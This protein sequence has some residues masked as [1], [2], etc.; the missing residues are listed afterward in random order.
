MA[1]TKRVKIHYRKLR[2]D[3][4]QF[5]ASTFRDAV[6]AAMDKILSD[7]SKVK[8]RVRNRL[9][10]V[11][12]QEGAQRLLNHFQAGDHY[13]F[14]T[15]CLFSPGELQALLKPQDAE[16]S[17][18]PEDVLDAWEIEETAAPRGNEY[19]HAISYWYVVGDHFYQIQHASL[20]SKSMEEYFTWL[21]RDQSK[22][23]GAANYVELKTVF[24]RTQVGDLD[25]IKAIEI[26]G[27]VPETV[28]AADLD[29]G[30]PRVVEYDAR[31]TV[32]DKLRAGFAKGRKIL[33][34]LLGEVEAQKI[35]DDMPDEASLEVIV[36]IGYRAKKRKIEKQFMRNLESGLRNIPD[37]EIKVRGRDGEIKGDDARLSTDMGVKKIRENSSLLDLDSA[38]TIMAEVHRRFMF[39]GKVQD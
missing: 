32:A 17:E 27:F 24:D 6:V 31:E 16:G 36:N 30:E 19:L 38:L 3:N 20:Q 21:L 15:I 26:G 12:N 18:I 22:V 23:I 11:S 35:I 25:D 5:P 10:G 8:G 28:S 33:N 9:T 7:G 1:T 13:A 37:G 29:D 14:G 34:D 4:D 39:D 2:R